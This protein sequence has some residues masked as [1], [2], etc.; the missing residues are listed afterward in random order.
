MVD[1]SLKNMLRT[2]IVSYQML[3]QK[4]VKNDES[5]QTGVEAALERFFH[6][7]EFL[8]KYGSLPTKEDTKGERLPP[9]LCGLRAFLS[10]ENKK[11]SYVLQKDTTTQYR[12]NYSQWEEGWIEVIEEK[13]DISRET[14]LYAN[15]VGIAT[16][17][18]SCVQTCKITELLYVLNKSAFPQEHQF[19]N[20]FQTITYERFGEDANNEGITTTTQDQNILLRRPPLPSFK[21][22]NTTS[23]N[24]L[25]EAF[26]D[27]IR[28]VE[29]ES[30]DYLLSG[31]IH[32]KQYNATKFFHTCVKDL[33]RYTTNNY[34]INGVKI[35]KE[36]LTKIMEAIVPDQNQYSTIVNTTPLNERNSYSQIEENLRLQYNE[37]DAAKISAILQKP[38]FPLALLA[39]VSQA[40]PMLPAVAMLN[41]AK[42]A[43][44][45]LNFTKLRKNDDI[46]KIFNEFKANA[47]KFDIRMD[48]EG[49]LRC[50]VESFYPYIEP[51][52]EIGSSKAYSCF[53]VPQDFVGDTSLNNSLSI[54]HK[55]DELIPQIETGIVL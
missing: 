6:K 44:N 25:T 13:R 8:L 21:V 26:K 4:A 55:L 38:Q 36:T 19:S 32:S 42:F 52:G 49:N 41:D 10:T 20:G 31:K 3:A 30:F 43:V 29:K 17:K 22:T 14:P 45:V 15:Y 28:S 37:A 47:R 9:E 7:L 40:I 5:N 39:L 2:N 51:T 12:F 50:G 24:E 34:T 16:W 18:S 11:G 35:R 1:F 48:E 54:A 23:V 33:L 46:N 53:S 27:A